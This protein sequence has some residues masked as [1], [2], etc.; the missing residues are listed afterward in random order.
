MKLSSLMN[1][2]E[3]YL[4]RPSYLNESIREGIEEAP[5]KAK[6]NPSWRRSKEKFQKSFVFKTREELKSFCNYILDYEINTGVFFD[7][8][9]YSEKNKVDVSMSSYQAGNK[10]KRVLS[11]I[12]G[13]SK[14]IKESYKKYD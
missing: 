7:I 10:T 3:N 6:Y 11:K 13:I 9:I 2:G 4:V 8:T 12:D 1:Q 14:D 5:I